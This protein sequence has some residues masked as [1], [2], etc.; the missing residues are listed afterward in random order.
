MKTYAKFAC[1]GLLTVSLTL[2]GCDK[3]EKGS[4]NGGSSGVASGSGSASAYA[5]PDDVFGAFKTAASKNE[6]KKFMGC[7]TQKSQNE[8]TM[9]TIM[10]SAFLPMK[11]MD[12]EA[13]AK[14]L[15]EEIE[16]VM[17]KHGLSEDKME[18]MDPSVEPDY[19]KIF[20]PVKDKSAFV[21]DLFALI[22]RE[23]P[24]TPLKMLSSATLKDVQ[25]DGEK[26]IG[27]LVV[28]GGDEEIEFVKVDGSWLIKM[29]NPGGPAQGGPG[30]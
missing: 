9:A 22:T 11:H 25:V 29:P 3:D 19:E 6:L 17:A 23:D 18:K 21:A 27:K 14:A 1:I 26:A 4:G 5:S 24:E 16:S 20:A 2:S 28:D 13:K 8:F 15:G 30:N 12:D 10:M 7:M